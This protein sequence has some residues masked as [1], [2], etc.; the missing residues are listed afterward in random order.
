MSLIDSAV[1]YGLT[2]ARALTGRRVTLRTGP[3]G[4]PSIAITVI[5]Q[6]TTDDAELAHG[7]TKLRGMRD[8]VLYLPDL[9]FN[10]VI[11]FPDRG[12]ELD[13]VENNRIVTYK[14]LPPNATDDVHERI[15]PDENWLV[16]HTKRLSTA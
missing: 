4:S 2:M 3:P 13:T 9:V 16:I 1:S 5:P 15:T 6:A 12:W 8:W 11:Q 14:L 10:G 7:V